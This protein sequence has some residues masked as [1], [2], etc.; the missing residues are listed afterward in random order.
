MASFGA[1]VRSIRMSKNISQEDLANDSG[2][3]YSHI[4]RIENGK[5]NP[6]LSHIMKIAEVLGVPAKELLDF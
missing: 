3:A 5:T 2:F 1:R 4:N 6:S